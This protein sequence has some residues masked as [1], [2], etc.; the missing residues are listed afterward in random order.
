MAK[1]INQKSKLAKVKKKTG[2]HSKHS[3][4]KTSKNY[5]KKNVGQGK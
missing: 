4:L 1:E 5:K 3:E 2:K